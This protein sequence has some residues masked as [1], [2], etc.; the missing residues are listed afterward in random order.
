MGW[1]EGKVWEE[2][3]ECRQAE[4]ARRRWQI[5]RGGGVGEWVCAWVDEAGDG[6]CEGRGGGVGE[7]GGLR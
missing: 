3:R 1:G 2:G 4:G 6:R 5:G 7:A